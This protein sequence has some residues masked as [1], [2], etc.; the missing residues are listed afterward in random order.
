MKKTLICITIT[1][2]LMMSIVSSTANGLVMAVGKDQSMSLLAGVPEYQEAAQIFNILEDP[3]S[4]LTG[5][6]MQQVCSSTGQELCAAYGAISNPKNFVLSKLT[7]TACQQDKELCDAYTK[8]MQVYGATQ[9]PQQAASQYAIQEVAKKDP[10]VGG[11]L[12]QAYMVKNYAS[13][14]AAKPGEK[15]NDAATAAGKP[16]PAP[17]SQITTNAVAENQQAFSGKYLQES[18]S[19]CLMG[20]SPGQTTPS[21]GDAITPP[22]MGDI[23]NCQ[24]G[25]LDSQDIS[26]L[27]NDVAKAKLSG[28]GCS[29]SRINGKV[30]LYN[31]ESCA[32]TVGELKIE[33][34]AKGTFAVFD[35]VEENIELVQGRFVPKVDNQLFTFNKKSYK[36]PLGAILYYTNEKFYTDLSNA[37][38]DT[39]SIITSSGSKKIETKIKVSDKAMN[40]ILQDQGSSIIFTGDCEVGNSLNKVRFSGS[41]GLDPSGEISNLGQ[42]TKAL[43]YKS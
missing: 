5:V 7:D 14:L 1:I 31:S 15:G 21:N 6:A 18:L 20:F 27:F 39:F 33:D 26:F 34:S 25:E 41:I 37:D 40:C 13:I 4:A 22:M 17:T 24:L 19:N 36:V 2:L 30:Y 12:T 43:I 3:K 23:T 8:G 11:I 29:V 38:T 16:V 35:I 10:K 9:N 42:D 28:K 32:I